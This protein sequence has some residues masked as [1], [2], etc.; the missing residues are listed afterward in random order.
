VESFPPVYSGSP[1]LFKICCILDNRKE[2]TTMSTRKS[3]CILFGILVILAWALESAVQVGAETMNYRFFTWVIRGEDVPV[4]D[5]EGH[6][7][8]IAIRGAFWVFENGE[9]ATIT[10]VATRDLIKGSGPFM[11]YVTVNFA[12]GSIIIIKSQGALGGTATGA[13]ASGGWTSEIIKGTGRFE[14]IKGTQTAKAKYLPIIKGEAGARGYGE[15]T[16]TYTLPPK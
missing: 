5:V 12:D 15:G 6:M 16:I 8:G 10:H 14:G 11:Q 4:N 7:V 2:K 13:L 3:I 9:V 1:F